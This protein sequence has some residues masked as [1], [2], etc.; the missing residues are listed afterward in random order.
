MSDGYKGA[1]GRV[2]EQPDWFWSLSGGIDSVAAFLTTRQALE[3]RQQGGNYAKKPL[4]IYLDTRIGVPLNR[5]YVEELCDRYDVQLWTLRTDEKFEEW[6]ARDG[7]PGS[8]AHQEVRNELKGRQSSKLISLADHPVMVMGLAADESDRRAALPKVKQQRRHAEVYPVHRLS[9]KERVEII[10]RAEDC[11]IN[12]LWLEPA[13]IKDCACLAHGDPSELDT[14]EELFPWFGQRIREY[15]EAI[16]ADGLHGTLGWSGLTSDEQ[17]ALESGYEQMTLCSGVAANATPTACGH[18]ERRPRENQSR[19]VCRCC[20]SR[21]RGGP[22]RPRNQGAWSSMNCAYDG[23]PF[24]T[25]FLNSSHPSSA[26]AASTSSSVMGRSSASGSVRAGGGQSMS[27]FRMLRIVDSVT[28][29]PSV[30]R[31]ITSPS[32][33]SPVSSS[34]MRSSM[35]SCNSW[36]RASPIQA[37][38][39]IDQ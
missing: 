4:A 29:L 21:T 19:T 5:L 13:A 24:D 18:S 10:L 30:I 2:S 6:L 17:T 28:P 14:T 1:P 7:A 37:H 12:P 16:D 3:T 35:A 38:R 20:M 36:V 25:E 26:S 34:A 27:P 32:V 15:E 22:T 39:R 11:P 31:P 9:L 23:S 33:S 8:G